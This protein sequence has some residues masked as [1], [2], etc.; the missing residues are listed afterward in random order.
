[1]TI[2]EAYRRFSRLDLRAQVPVII[3]LTS[4]QI[5]LLNQAQLYQESK[6]SFGN[7][8]GGYYFQWYED[9]KKEMNPGLG[10]LVDLYLTGA[11]YSGFFVRVEND[12]FIIG[13]NDSKSGDL[14]SKYGQAIFGLTDESKAK[15][16]V[17]AFFS[18]LKNYIEEVSGFAMS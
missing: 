8:L 11:F 16:T 7:S 14:E 6:D 5:I 10:G 13:S 4:E 3:E 18:A 1:M 2:N 15:Y 9:L 17:E 12:V